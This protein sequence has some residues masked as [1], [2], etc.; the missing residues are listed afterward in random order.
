MK[1]HGEK[2]TRKKEQAIVALLSH[3][4]IPE[5]ARATG[6]AAV[7]LW[8]WLQLDGF[9]DEYQKARR[10]AVGRAIDQVQRAAAGAVQTLE[11]VMSDEQTPASARV[12]AAKTVLDSALKAVELEDVQGRL[13]ALE[14]ALKQ[15][16]ES[17]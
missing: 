13:Q 2:L 10:D 16:G 3:G 6:I 7:T 1:G 5:A 17:K 9:R 14:S 11:G 12:S 4:S 8:R 15:R